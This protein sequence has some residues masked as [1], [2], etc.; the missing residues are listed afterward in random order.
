MQCS[1]VQLSEMQCTQFTLVEPTLLARMGH[2]HMAVL[3]RADAAK[4]VHLPLDLLDG[5]LKLVHFAA[6]GLPL[7][8]DGLLLLH[9]HGQ[10]VLQHRGL[11]LV[12]H[13]Q[14]SLVA[15]AEFSTKSGLR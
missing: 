11:N 14:L 2:V 7:V 5:G 6:H 10:V 1:A 3:N 9:E 12:L 8:L 13:E 15:H 4:L